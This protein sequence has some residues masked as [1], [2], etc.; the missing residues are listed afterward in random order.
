MKD[1]KVADRIFA[2][3]EQDLQKL[4]IQYNMDFVFDTP[5]PKLADY[6]RNSLLN[7]YSI[8]PPKDE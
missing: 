3:F 8:K 4:L 1:E 6:V 2:Q 7:I 5:A